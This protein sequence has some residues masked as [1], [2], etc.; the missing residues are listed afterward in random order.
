MIEAQRKVVE[1]CAKALAKTKET[2]VNE[3]KEE[4]DE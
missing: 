4:R 2:S 1:A 3:Y